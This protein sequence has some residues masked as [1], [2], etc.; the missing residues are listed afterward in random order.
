[1]KSL[2]QMASVSRRVGEDAEIVFGGRKKT[3]KNAAAP[4]ND[5]ISVLRVAF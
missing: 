4:D 3:E 1:V 2:A 5:F